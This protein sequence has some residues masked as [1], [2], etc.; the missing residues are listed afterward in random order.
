IKIIHEPNDPEPERVI[1]T[2]RDGRH[3]VEPLIDF[4]DPQNL[5]LSNEELIA[6]YRDCARLAL[7]EKD[8]NRSIEMV[9]NLEQLT[10]I[11]QLIDLLGKCTYGK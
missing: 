5:T 6:K 10:D 9:Q 11:Q 1:F 8:I 4:R 7:S 3:L 2:L